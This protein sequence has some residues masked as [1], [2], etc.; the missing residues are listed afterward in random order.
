MYNQSYDDYMR[1][2]LG[3][4]NLDGYINNT[5]GCMTNQDI[6]SSSD[7]IEQM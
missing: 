2:I 4:P 6:Y 7:D 5:Y 3:Y 1:S